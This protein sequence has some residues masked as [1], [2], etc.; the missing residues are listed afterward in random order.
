MNNAF[1]A[2]GKS[3]LN[4]VFDVIG[5]IYPDYCFPVQKQATK[6]KI[7]TLTSSGGPKP[8]KVKVLTRRSKLHSLEKNVAAPASKKMEIEYIE[9]APWLRR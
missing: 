4:K 3:R 6:R 1:S 7:A 8:K 5:F 2:R 9:A